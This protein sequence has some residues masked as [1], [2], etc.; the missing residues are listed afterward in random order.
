MERIQFLRSPS[1]ID[2]YTQRTEVI[3]SK[4]LISFAFYN[5]EGFSIIMSITSS[6]KAFESNQRTPS[7]PRTPL[8]M[9]VSESA[10]IQRL[11]TLLVFRSGKSRDMLKL[12]YLQQFNKF[13]VLLEI[14]KGQGTFLHWLKS[15]TS[16]EWIKAGDTS[17]T[18]ERFTGP[19]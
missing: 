5:L 6:S 4:L 12:A 9:T 8:M 7:L 2:I 18:Q 14:F 19:D 16:D 10:L 1:W 15:S 13:Q 11:L 17:L 3:P